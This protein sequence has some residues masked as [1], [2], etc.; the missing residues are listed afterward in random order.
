[1]GSLDP[2]AV[3]ARELTAIGAAS[4]VLGAASLLISFGYLAVENVHCARV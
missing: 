2:L 1:V 3:T 4:I